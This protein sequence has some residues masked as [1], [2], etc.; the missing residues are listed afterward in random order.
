M[1]QFTCLRAIYPGTLKIFTTVPKISA[2]PTHSFAGSPNS[3]INRGVVSDPAPTPVRAMNT[4]ITNPS[5]NSTW[6]S[7]RLNMDTALQ[8]TFSLPASG[9]RIFGIDRQSRAGLAADAGVAQIV[10][11]QRRNIV[12]GQV[13][14][15]IAI[16]PLGQRADFFEH[17]PAR[18]LER[19]HHL[20]VRACG[21]LFA[22]QRRKPAVV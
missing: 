9:A 22:A 17:L 12:S 15:D 21:R 18:Q 1:R 8:L 16:G 19:F 20:K 11:R 3:R 13:G 7:A 2:V 4:A 5:A 6:S 14:P 10:E